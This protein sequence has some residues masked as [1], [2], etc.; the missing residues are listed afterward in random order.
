M[1]QMVMYSKFNPFR[2]IIFGYAFLI[3]AGTF[4]L[5]MPVSS[6]GNTWQPLLDAFFTA[7]SAVTTTGLGVVDIGS[8]Y[9]IFGQWVL[10]LLIQICGVGYMVFVSL[11]FMGFG[12][13]S[14]VS[15]M[16][17]I[18]ESINSP[19]YENAV[20]FIK[21]VLVFTVA[22]EL[23][24][25]I[26]L[27]ISWQDKMG[28][29]TALYQAFFHSV[30]A[31]CTA[32]FSTY[33]NGLAEFSG[34]NVVYVVMPLLSVA[35]GIGFF[36]LYDICSF[37][38]DKIKGE[39]QVQLKTHTK[40]MLIAMGA[41][42]TGAGLIYYFTEYA[43]GEF[44]ISPVKNTVFQVVSASTT[45][46]YNTVDIGKL[47]PSTIFMLALLM[48]IGAGPGS[49]AGGIKVISVGVFAVMFYSFVS[50]Q[51]DAVIF[52]RKIPNIK[53]ETI[54]AIC[55]G[56]AVWV[57]LAM[58]VLLITEKQEFLKI[59][60]E[61]MSAFAGAGLSTGITGELTAGGKIII[62][63]TMIFGRI[64]P[65]ALGYFLVGGGSK[66]RLEYPEAEII[67]G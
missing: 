9:S 65:L 27:F 11:I 40:F 57:L 62:A 33:K 63:L 42:L 7:V 8:Y 53:I 16:M 67:V 20:K 29:A 6:A 50:R 46:G 3:A 15:N 56:A 34:D 19:S 60:F 54:T 5:M 1:A 24:G 14:G 13:K 47:Q 35:G 55:F 26:L 43:A 59:F 4:L 32:G 10:L 51:K 23:M 66:T 28:A 48:F 61:V 64:G 21:I 18:K 31:F 25:T 41:I 36:V 2:V 38:R 44:G 58:L 49:T 45:T 30:S 12:R 17:L 22:F 52:K 39:P 37:V